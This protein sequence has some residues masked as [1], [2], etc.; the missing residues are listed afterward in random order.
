MTIIIPIEAVRIG[1]ARRKTEKA[2]VAALAESIALLGLRTPITVLSADAEGRHGLVTGRNR[3]EACRLLGHTE[4]AAVVEGDKLTAQLWE[5]AENFHRSDLTAIQ[6]SALVGRWMR[7]ATRMRKV[8]PGG[9]LGGIQPKNQGVR[10]ASRALGIP[11]ETVRR[12][13]NVSEHL[14]S[15]A[16]RAAERLGLAKNM[17]ALSSAA[18]CTGADEQVADLQRTAARMA[19]RKAERSQMKAVLAG[20]DK[21]RSPQEAF[22][23][24][25]NSFDIVMKVEIRIW[26][27]SKAA[28]AYF[29]EQEQI[30]QRRKAM[31]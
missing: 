13:F 3:L 1:A 26:L 10:G 2:K 31:H 5:I 16:K 11:K 6:R 22:D 25:F 4:I 21:P 27:L 30:E 7:L 23:R 19:K 8:A 28:E 18:S 12:A 17:R 24:W 29:E 9:H 15:A 20:T 14:S